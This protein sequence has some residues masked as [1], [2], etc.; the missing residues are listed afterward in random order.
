[1]RDGVSK[2]VIWNIFLLQRKMRLFTFHFGVP[3]IFNVLK[4]R[5]ESQRAETALTPPPP[6][7]HLVSSILVILKNFQACPH[8]TNIP[9]VHN[10]RVEMSIYLEP[11]LSP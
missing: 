11:R 3:F 9:A 2:E 6:N 4:S 10:K 7:N 5:N 8:C 1:M